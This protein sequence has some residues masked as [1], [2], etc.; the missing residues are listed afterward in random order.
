MSHEQT[1]KKTRAWCGGCRREMAAPDPDMPGVRT[2]EGC[3]VT[4][5]FSSEGPTVVVKP[6]KCREVH[7]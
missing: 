2:C 4:I 7:L 1:L 6:G 5:D 3:G